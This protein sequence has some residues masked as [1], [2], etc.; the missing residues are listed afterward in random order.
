M[1]IVSQSNHDAGSM[2]RS[3]FQSWDV[4]K[5]S[6]F[7]HFESD[8]NVQRLINVCWLVLYWSSSKVSIEN[9]KMKLMTSTSMMLCNNACSCSCLCLKSSVDNK[10]V[11][12]IVLPFGFHSLNFLK[13]ITYQHSYF[14]GTQVH[15]PWFL[16]RSDTV[17][18]E[19]LSLIEGATLWERP[20]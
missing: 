3:N 12:T 4:V 10:H 14:F 5:L 2:P 8:L 7:Y 6:Y 11:H 19:S 17:S 16:C 1:S 15:T 20:E 9:L 13:I 18:K